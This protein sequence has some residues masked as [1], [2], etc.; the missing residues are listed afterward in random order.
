MTFGTNTPRDLDKL[1]PPQ[2]LDAEQAV[3]GSILKD[4]EAMAVTIGVLDADSHFYFPKHQM[5]FRACL[6]LY[7]KS[8]PCDITTVANY[9]QGAGQL[10]KIGGRVY[11]VELVEAV[12]STSNVEHYAQIV[13]DKSLMRRLIDTSNEISRTAYDGEMDVRELLDTAEGSI[14]S[15]AGSRMDQG[16]ISLRKLIPDT[17][18]EIDLIQS[19]GNWVDSV[20]SG[21]EEIDAITQGFRKG[22]FIVIAARPSMGKA[23]PLTAKILT[24]KGWSIMG[25]LSVGSKVI[26]SD[27]LGHRVTAIYP[28]GLKK[29]YRITFSDGGSTECCGEHLWFTQ[30]RAERRKGCKGSVKSIETIKDTIS[31]ETTRFVPNHNIPVV[32]PIEFGE[33]KPLRLHPYLMGLL[34]G[35]GDFA[36]NV[37]IT[38]P[39]AD[40]LTAFESHLPSGDTVT[41]TEIGL[42]VRRKVK[43]SLP[44]ETKKQLEGYGLSG[45][46]SYSKFIPCDYLHA[47]IPDRISLLRGLCDTDGHVTESGQLVE[48]CSSSRQLAE[49]FRLLARS[50][51]GIVSLREKQPTFS[52][53]GEK[54]NGATAYRIYASFPNGLCPV[55]SEKHLAAWKGGVPRYFRSISSIESAGEAECQCILIDS[56][57]HLYVTDD[58][59]LTHNTA[60]ALNIADMMTDTNKEKRTILVFSIE[61]SKEEVAMRMLCSRAKVSQA[62]LRRGKLSNAE[63][64]AITHAGNHFAQTEIIIDDSATLSPLQMRAKARRIK[65][66]YPNLSMIIVD[67]IQM[68]HGTHRVENRQQEITVISRSLKTLAKELELPVIA[69]SQL[70]RNVENRPDRRP[71]LAD[72][73]ESGAIEQDADVVMFVYRPEYYLSEDERNLPKNFDKIGVAEIIVAKQRNGPTGTAKLTFLKE[74]ALFKNSTRTELNR[75]LPREAEQEGIAF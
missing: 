27:G 2:S 31:R 17:I 15:I 6:S 14:F 40:V 28:Q 11:L 73:R 67:Y 44:S 53:L 72:L 38:K 29:I 68:M 22:N 70:S 9:L 69:C 54:R 30:T 4:E 48:F 46:D 50:L 10:E 66:Q 43:C 1:Q 61:M 45:C 55:S 19:G 63:I 37:R 13:L 47:S 59:I 32:A 75:E 24:P 74:F 42:R 8:E 60:L 20:P 65:A 64:D 39:E 5:I 26:G 71:Q 16:H 33:L 56:P 49:D 21:F 36:G 23:Q 52:Y 35:D 25:R 57:D 62:K 7:E 18:T 34:L 41:A 58:F 3:L 12:A 51:G